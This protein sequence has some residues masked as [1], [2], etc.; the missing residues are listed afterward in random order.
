MNFKKFYINGGR[1]SITILY[2]TKYIR[3]HFENWWNTL[4]Y[5]LTVW[6]T[7]KQ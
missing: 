3:L 2:Q 5:K 4:M 1:F 6:T 7:K